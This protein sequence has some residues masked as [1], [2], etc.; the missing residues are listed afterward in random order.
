MF[1]RVPKTPI[2]TGV[3]F[4]NRSGPPFERDPAL[5][6]D[7]TLSR[8]RPPKVRIRPWQPFNGECIV[9]LLSYVRK[10][11]GK[12]GELSSSQ[13]DK[14]VLAQDA[15]RILTFCESNMSSPALSLAEYVASCIAKTFQEVIAPLISSNSMRAL[16]TSFLSGSCRCDAVAQQQQ[17]SR[18]YQSGIPTYRV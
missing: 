6:L 15:I 9:I 7:L 10:R 1:W 17:V 5:L 14:A 2:Y 18:A 4:L 11:T 3:F 13:K 8:T 12:R 16:F